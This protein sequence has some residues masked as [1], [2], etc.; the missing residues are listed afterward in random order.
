MDEQDLEEQNL[1]RELEQEQEEEDDHNFPRLHNA[2]EFSHH[3][4]TEELN[5]RDKESSGF[6]DE[7]RTA[8]NKIFQVEYEN[9]IAEYRAK[10]KKELEEKQ[11]KLEDLRQRR[12]RERL[13]KEEQ[14]ALSKNAILQ[15][16]LKLARGNQTP[17]DIR[18]SVDPIL[19]RA[20][21]RTLVDCSSI[22]SLDISDRA[23]KNPIGD[24]SGVFLAKH[25]ASNRCIKKLDLSC[26]DIGPK[27]ITALGDMLEENKSLKTLII[28][29]NPICLVFN[30]PSKETALKG[31]NAIKN[32]SLA[33]DSK[34]VS[35]EQKLESGMKQHQTLDFS[36][37]TSFADSIMRNN[38][39]I[40]LSLNGCTL[41]EEG[42]EILADGLNDN[43]SIVVMNIRNTS[44]STK[45]LIHIKKTLD[46]NLEKRSIIE[47]TIRR[48][49][50]KLAVLA[51][52]DML[53]KERI[54]EEK[55]LNEWVEEMKYK[56]CQNKLNFIQEEKEQD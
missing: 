51:Q 41:T 49:E 36:G 26:N 39:L 38:S 17:S 37:I 20:V 6:V 11:Q 9:A 4:I 50:E 52:Q 18:L 42:G 35:L 14:L 43:N 45:T 15:H 3:R 12:E 22:I 34:H 31:N 32:A 5:M 23:H 1:L 48:E 2:D 55:R 33:S 53:E 25:L 10:K 8:L 47:E 30:T 19:V 56:R 44:C 24:E 29:E 46:R 40:V 16:W 27:S 54:E 7:D 28:D 21:A 13:L